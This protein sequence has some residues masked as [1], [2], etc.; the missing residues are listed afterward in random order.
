MLEPLANLLSLPTPEHILEH[1]LAKA[2]GLQLSIKRDDLIHP[3]ICG[4]KWRKLKSYLQDAQGKESLTLL[5]YGGAF[6]NH[7]VALAQVGKE[8]GW[9]TIGIIRSYQNTVANPTIETM[10]T[11]GMQCYFLHPN[12]YNLKEAGTVVKE[13]IASQRAYVIPE[14]GSGLHSI[15]GVGAIVEELETSY[16]HIITPIGSGGTAA[17]LVRALKNTRTQVVALAP[18]KGRFDQLSGLD[19]LNI[20]ERKKLQILNA[21]PNLK[22]AG[23][24]PDIASY[25][26][27]FYRQ[28]GI[29]LDPIYTS[30]MMM[31]VEKLM[32]EDFFPSASRILVVH[33]GGLQGIAGYNYRY[34]LNLPI[35]DTTY[36]N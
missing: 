29:I 24:H 22:F 31:S 13:I 10:K 3:I 11:L 25:I 32:Q 27:Q 20:E 14:G 30:R 21:I 16:S 33:T 17:G 26:H 28:Y 1:P 9:T 12:E 4:N 5:S 35:P 23:F 34:K 2:K 7:L 8:L 36:F 19:I 15:K 18:F 6:S